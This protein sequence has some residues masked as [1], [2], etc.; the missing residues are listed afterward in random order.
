MDGNDMDELGK[1]LTND[2]HVVDSLNIVEI[3]ELKSVNKYIEHRVDESNLV[4]EVLFLPP[5]GPHPDEPY[6]DV[7]NGHVNNH[8]NVGHAE[9][10]D[11]YVDVEVEKV[12]ASKT[13]KN[14]AAIHSKKK[15]SVT[16]PMAMGKGS[17]H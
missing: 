12:A 13:S 16:K 6:G 15:A 7:Q 9:G 2:E 8:A 3:Y 17:C 14:K 11:I 1:S 5:P 4:G 10:D